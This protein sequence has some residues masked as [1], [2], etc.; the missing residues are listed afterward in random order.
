VLTA[1]L[2]VPGVV[3]A[4]HQF[5]DVPNTNAFHGDIDQV[6]DARIT[7]GCGDGNYCPTAAVTREQMA[8][9]LA[10]TGGRVGYDS[11]NSTNPLSTSGSVPTVLATVTIKAGNVPGGTVMVQL[12]GAF[13]IQAGSST[14]LPST[15]EFRFR[16]QSSGGF[17][18]GTGY[19]TLA[20]IGIQSGALVGVVEQASGTTKTYE[21][22][23][24]RILGSNSLSTFGWMSAAY[25]PFSEDGDDNLN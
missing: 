16:E 11:S 25:F 10:R 2:L 20:S 5:N 15:G 14:G 21:L 6:Y 24:W 4:S 9:F 18:S 13:H 23:G 22:V 8:A 7:N 3:L 19:S 12:I 1:G 17:V